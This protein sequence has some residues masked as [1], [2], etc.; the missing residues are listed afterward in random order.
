MWPT[1]TSIRQIAAHD[2][3][4]VSGLHSLHLSSQNCLTS[5]E[6][7]L[8]PQPERTPIL[9]YVYSEGWLVCL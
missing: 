3:A 2:G 7:L 5:D 8:Q 1:I 9:V 4:V 6:V